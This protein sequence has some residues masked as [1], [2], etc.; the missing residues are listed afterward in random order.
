MLTYFGQ[1]YRFRPTLPILANP[2]TPRGLYPDTFTERN[3]ASGMRESVGLPPP[4]VEPPF[5]FWLVRRRACLACSLAFAECCR[6]VHLEFK[7]TPD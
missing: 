7:H 2:T 4:A 3:W 5:D 6:C 1:P